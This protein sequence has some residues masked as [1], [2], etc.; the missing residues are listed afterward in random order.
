MIQELSLQVT[1]RM[2]WEEESIVPGHLELITWV[3]VDLNKKIKRA[4]NKM[5]S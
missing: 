1:K 2:E 3:A 5:L 4:V